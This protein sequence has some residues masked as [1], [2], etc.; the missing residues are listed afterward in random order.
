M[1]FNKTQLRQVIRSEKRHLAEQRRLHEVEYAMDHDPV[2][3]F[4]TELANAWDP[5]V[6]QGAMESELGMV[7]ETFLQDRGH[8]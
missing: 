6:G 8:S 5:A 1:K 3:R 4:E 7:I 2:G